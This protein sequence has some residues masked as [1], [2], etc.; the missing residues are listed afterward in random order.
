MTRHTDENIDKR[1][2][3][4]LRSKKLEVDELCRWWYKL[5]MRMHLACINESRSVMLDVLLQRV[6]SY[7]ELLHYRYDVF[8]HY[9]FHLFQEVI[10]DGSR[11]QMPMELHLVRDLGC[12][13]LGKSI[14]EVLWSTVLCMS[15][16][17]HF[18]KESYCP[19]V[20]GCR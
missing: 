1:V 18:W 15:R 17:K 13:R 16:T 14:D 2:D 12:A 9:Y 20:C 8:R 11:F 4:V 10:E 6:A 3:R 7:T 5:A 19:A